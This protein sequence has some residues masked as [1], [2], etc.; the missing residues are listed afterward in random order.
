[1]ASDLT[2]KRV[3]KW[4]LAQ[5]DVTEKQRAGI[6]LKVSWGQI[7]IV[8][9]IAIVADLNN[10]SGSKIIP[11]IHVTVKLIFFCRVTSPIMF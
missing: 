6:C 1:M 3:P 4:C 11:L 9:V 7:R 8:L 5:L 10:N 2:Q